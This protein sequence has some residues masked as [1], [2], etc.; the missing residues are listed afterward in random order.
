M[1]Q[2]AASSTFSSAIQVLHVILFRE[3][4]S[5]KLLLPIA[6]F[7]AMLTHTVS[8]DLDDETHSI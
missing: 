2:P 4:A 6:Q 5:L 3:A 1:M 8:G 7:P